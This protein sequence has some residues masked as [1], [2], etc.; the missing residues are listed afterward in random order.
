MVT[1][2]GAGSLRHWLVF[3]EKTIPEVKDR[4]GA[5]QEE[6]PAAF[7]LRGNF[8]PLGSREFPAREKR[9][10]ETSARFTIRYKRELTAAKAADQY[11]I[12][13]TL[14]AVLDPANA[15]VFD[16]YPP[17]DPDGRRRYLL[18]EGRETK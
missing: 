14:D 8:A 1:I 10:A 11:R 15:Q 13:F 5:P 12:V 4:L 9:H 16:I 3:Q 18:I 2:L 7:R 17:I 6:W